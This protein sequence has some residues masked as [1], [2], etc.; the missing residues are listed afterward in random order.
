MANIVALVYLELCVS[1]WYGICHIMIVIQYTFESKVFPCWLLSYNGIYLKNPSPGAFYQSLRWSQALKCFIKHFAH[2]LPPTW[3]GLTVL[4]GHVFLESFPARHCKLERSYRGLLPGF[5][6]SFSVPFFSDEVFCW[7]TY[8]A[9]L[10]WMC[11]R[12]VRA[13]TTLK[14]LFEGLKITDRRT[15]FES[16]SGSAS[17]ACH[18]VSLM[19]IRLDLH[20]ED[21]TNTRCQ[22]PQRLPTPNQ[23]GGKLMDNK[24]QHSLHH[25]SVCTHKI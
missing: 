17:S 22:S 25:A 15:H 3:C 16:L 1:T 12:R 19:Q 8:C 10:I 18:Y 21:A 13:H 7:C 9:I 6:A 20:S 2:L 14:S 4:H 5:L 11:L 23:N 24:D